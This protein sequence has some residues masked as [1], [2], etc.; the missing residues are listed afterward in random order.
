MWCIGGV[1][2]GLI[3]TT[4]CRN[5]RSRSET[6]RAIR[7]R[8]RRHGEAGPAILLRGEVILWVTRVPLLRGRGCPARTKVLPSTEP[9]P[10]PRLTGGSDPMALGRGEAARGRGDAL[11]LLTT[12]SPAAAA[13]PRRWRSSETVY[14]PQPDVIFHP[15]EAVHDQGRLASQDRRAAMTALTGGQHIARAMRD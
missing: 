9:R 15:G 8:R 10:G 7:R 11:F 14:G 5:G 1:T 3:M 2:L 6:K 4:G 13:Q 12:G